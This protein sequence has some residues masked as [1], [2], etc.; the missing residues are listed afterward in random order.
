MTISETW[1]CL[2]R[3]I[4]LRSMWTTLEDSLSCTGMVVYMR[5]GEREKG[6]REGEGREEEG[7]KGG[8]GKEGRGEEGREKG[9]RDEKRRGRNGRGREK[10]DRER[11]SAGKH[12][13][14]RMPRNFGKQVRAI[15]RVC[16]ACI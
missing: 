7:R 6:G 12:I 10:D 15:F 14:R 9:G 5:E 4:C 1:C 16:F 11:E 8:R 2:D 3:E 13:T